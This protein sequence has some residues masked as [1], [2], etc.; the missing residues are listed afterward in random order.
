MDIRKECMNTQR[1]RMLRDNLLDQLDYELGESSR[2][3]IMQRPLL[4]EKIGWKEEADVV[5]KT[6][7]NSERIR[8]ITEDLLKVV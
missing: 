6:K 4:R 5:R 2:L 8:V 1:K 3:F 7:E